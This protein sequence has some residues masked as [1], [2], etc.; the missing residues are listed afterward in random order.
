[1]IISDQKN[2]N[3]GKKEKTITKCA[4]LFICDYMAHMCAAY[5]ITLFV[6]W[7]GEKIFE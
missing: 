2:D 5:A 6:E 3:L 7:F 4:S 1:M